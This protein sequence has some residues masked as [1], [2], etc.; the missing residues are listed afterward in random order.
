MFL[1]KV[2]WL[3]PAS[4]QDKYLSRKY[5]RQYND[6]VESGKPLPP[7]H[8]IKQQRIAKYKQKHNID[9]LVETGT[10]LGDMIWAQRNSFAHIYSIELSK[11]FA[12]LA[13]KRFSKYP[14]ITII[15][16]DSGEVMTKLIKQ[17]NKKAIFWLDGHYSGG[18]TACAGKECPVYEEL[19]AIFQS[20]IEHVLLIDDA[21]CFVGANSYPTV[22]EL[23]GVVFEK[24]PNSTINIEDDCIIVELRK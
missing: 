9:T 10:Y 2:L 23:S 21:R 17:I 12:D 11:V 24:Y 3:L 15:E 8:T 6:W 1:K 4:I 19:E 20:D 13:K 16:G 7:V 18:A 22:E 5:N 14:H